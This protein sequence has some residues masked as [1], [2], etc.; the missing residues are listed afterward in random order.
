MDKYDLAILKDIQNLI[1]VFWLNKKLESK[2]KFKSRIS[3]NDMLDAEDRLNRF[4]PVVKKLFPETGDGIIES[5]LVCAPNLQKNLQ[6]YYRVELKGRLLLKCDN[7]LR[8]AGSIKARGGIYEVFK[9]A[10]R[11]AMTAG[12]LTEKDNYSKLIES[13]CKALFSRHKIAV[14]ST[15]NLGLSIGI[16]SAA[17]GFEVFVHMSADAKEWKKELLRKKGVKVIEYNADYSTAV[18]EGRKLASSDP[19]MYFV[20]DENSLDLFLGYS[21]AAFR[22]KRQLEELSIN[23]DRTHP[24]YVYLP[25][26]VGGAPGG[27]TFG[28][29]T[30]FGNNVHCFFAEPTHS[31]CMLLGL[32]TGQYGDINVN[33]FGIDNKTEAD[34]LAVARPSELV[35]ELVGNLIE[36]CYTVEDDELFKLLTMVKDSE[37]LKIET[38]AGAGLPGP[39]LTDRPFADNDKITHISWLTGGLLLPE[40]VDENAYEKGQ[41][42]L[43]MM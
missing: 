23:I 6:A 24:L 22:L 29:K 31:P 33:D 10:E 12:L 15:G 27:I 32:L 7:S 13:E 34:G 43:K 20:D 1:P 42:L 17:L 2:N 9:H 37:K 21:T 16:S 41:S 30:L 26:G 38:S 39:F 3:L 5:P 35:S 25:C 28:L 40:E 8:V 4:A 19:N 18:E 14:S 11:L 36:G